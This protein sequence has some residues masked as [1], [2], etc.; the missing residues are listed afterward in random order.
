VRRAHPDEPVVSLRLLE[1]QL[2]ADRIVLLRELRSLG[3]TLTPAGGT[4]VVVPGGVA[5]A[6][7]RARVEGDE[8]ARALE[9]QLREWATRTGLA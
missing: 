6:L 8:F 3:L 1:A 7:T 9:P 4:G 2:D 5:W